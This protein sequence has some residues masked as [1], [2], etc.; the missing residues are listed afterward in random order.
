M[1]S[2][3]R[4]IVFV[5]Q[6]NG[7]KSQ[8]A[9]AL[10]RSVAGPEVRVT[11]ASTKPGTALNQQSVDSLAEIGVSVGDEHPKQLTPEMIDAADLIVV[12]GAEARV[13]E[14]PGVVIETWI[15]G[16]PA[17]RGIE[18]MDRMR[19]VR[20]DIHARVEALHARV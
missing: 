13:P 20:D 15:T 9:A 10:L 14:T 17:E 18:G 8:M 6:K 19:L 16:E 1:T 3:P 12:L 4:N 2:S 11:S 7:G 5:C